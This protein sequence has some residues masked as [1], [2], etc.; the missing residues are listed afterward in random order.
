F[1]EDSN[2]STL[3]VDL[4]IVYNFSDYGSL[5]LT[6]TFVR[7]TINKYDREYNDLYGM[8]EFDYLK[9]T[10]NHNIIMLN[11]FAKYDFLWEKN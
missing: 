4:D 9:D 11:L 3:A 2:N 6:Y 10:F 8:S 7:E 1:L 5:S